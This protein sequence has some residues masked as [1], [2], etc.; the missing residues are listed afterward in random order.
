VP[1]LCDAISLK[2]GD[3]AID[4]ESA[5]DEE[6]ILLHCSCL[7][8]KSANSNYLELAHFTVQEFLTNIESNSPFSIYS[9]RKDE[10]QPLLARTCL[11]YLLM[12]AFQ[13]DVV[14][15]TE[16]WEEQL[17][18]HPLR[19]HAALYWIE[20]AE[21]SWENDEI[22]ALARQLFHPF[23]TLCF[24]SWARDYFFVSRWKY[25]DSE[26][27]RQLALD[28]ATILIF[29]GSVTPIHL[30]AAIGLPS[31]CQ[32]L[33]DSD[34]EVNQPSAIGTPLHC[35]LVG[36]LSLSDALHYED[37]LE[38]PHEFMWEGR[39]QVLD[40]LIA[41]GADLTATY[42][43]PYG[44]EYSCAKLALH[45]SLG[46]GPRHPLITLVAAGAK[47]DKGLLTAFEHLIDETDYNLEGHEE[48]V[49]ILI[50]RLE[51]NTENDIIKGDLLTAALRFKSSA[52]L[53]K[54]RGEKEGPWYSL[55]IPDEELREIFLRAIRFD[56]TDAM[57]YL[58][59]D[60]R[61]NVSSIDDDGETFLHIA[62]EHEATNATKMLLSLGVNANAK[63]KVGLTPLHRAVGRETRNPECVLALL[64]ADASIAMQTLNGRTAWHIAAQSNNVVALKILAARDGQK[65][66]SLVTSQ[67]EGFIPL[68]YAASCES[69]AA[70]EFL[71]S[72]TTKV[73]ET[74]PYGLGIVHYVVQMNSIKLLRLLRA[75]GLP[76]DQ[77]SKNGGTALHFIPQHVDPDV[78]RF[79]IES[80]VEPSSTDE[81]GHSPLHR[82]IGLEISKDQQVFELLATNESLPLV[83]KYGGTALHYA[84]GFTRSP[85]SFNDYP[86]RELYVK[87]LI[88]KGA[89]FNC[90]NENGDSCITLLVERHGRMI[91]F[92]QEDSEIRSDFLGLW[93]FIVEG[94][95]DLGLLNE[96]FQFLERNFRP[97]CW[98]ILFNEP[99]AQI[100][101]ARGVEVDLMCHTPTYVVGK[102][103]SAIHFACSV[104]SGSKL[105]EQILK[106]SKK[107]EDHDSRG[108]YLPHLAC[109]KGS[110]A[111]IY[112][113]KQLCDAGVDLGLHSAC[114]E[115]VTPLMLASAAGKLELVEY[116]LD[117]GTD[118]SARD[119]DGW[120]A[121]QYAALEGHADVLEL[122]IGRDIDWSY[123]VDILYKGKLL[124][125]CNMFHLSM[126]ADK[127][128]V[129]Q[130]LLKNSLAGDLES[131][132]GD[133]N[134]PL[135]LASIY[136]LVA[137]IEV[138][139]T[140]G[141]NIEAVSAKGLRP[142]HSAALAGRED[143]V[144][145][146]L[147]HGCELV[148]DSL[149]L[150]PELYALKENRPDIVRLLKDKSSQKGEP[151]FIV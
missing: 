131:W 10:V 110:K 141:A 116:L 49:G 149:G 150:T 99:L 50:E 82:F 23:K 5:I 118:F 96:S 94:T 64:D 78:V 109:E 36:I 12:D 19:A 11:T 93:S 51:E 6:T 14:E 34:C 92:A 84:V 100:L 27:D 41:N 127:L 75:K 126:L 137:H 145:V 69:E 72:E 65:P 117:C 81:D 17:V 38:T 33:L 83:G 28:E 16:K 32:W 8:R 45:A 148:A 24:L 42:R 37:W 105:F 68:F 98:A 97:L 102:D 132:N 89:S 130:W 120:Q 70:V 85:D 60:G 87:W 30:L 77:K 91:T 88:D 129:A 4:K 40:M 80:G 74:C 108:Y 112:H 144:R 134:T 111:E 13:H 57:E 18:R 140:A 63:S 124:S 67:K 71:L 43:D 3:R 9:Q 46:R 136:G 35:S 107:L 115:A 66:L 146:L 22:L 142:I 119:A 147:N 39:T 135:H 86:T 53:V 90:R 2:E 56:R 1:A 139:I 151:V 62:A 95:T 15:G 104:G 125:D 59:R 52:A 20:Y 47:L 122:Y 7:V 29:D 44:E 21:Y 114:S 48:F 103:W 26:K 76:I 138:L 128:H 55:N 106:A 25:L 123:S 133:G 54:L 73:P 31:L 61:L 121:V 101:L 113:L 143:I 58:L 79:L